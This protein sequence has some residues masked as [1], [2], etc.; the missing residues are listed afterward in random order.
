MQ[1]LIQWLQSRLTKN[2]MSTQGER[3]PKNSWLGWVRGLSMMFLLAG[4]VFSNANAQ[5]IVTQPMGGWRSTATGNDFSQKTNYPASSVNTEGI[6]PKAKIM[7]QIANFPKLSASQAK[8]SQLPAKLV[9]NGTDMPLKV[10]EGKFARP[11]AFGPGSNSVEVKYQ[12]NT[13]KVQFYE[14]KSDKGSAKLRVILSWDAD[15][16]DVDLH[17]V[18]PD[19]QHAWY[20]DQIVANGGGIDVDVTTGYGPEIY[21]NP[22]PLRGTYLIF[23]NY[24]GGYS[25]KTVVMATVTIITEE[26][27]GKEKREIFNVPL[28]K[29]GELQLVKSIQ[30]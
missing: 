28:R 29:P 10:N 5:V 3:I 7:G 30:Y 12:G 19:G 18:S 17:V 21:S 1:L 9:V 6:S 27:T 4:N 24:Y 26:G 11:W 20:G 14:A 2:L 16:T 25:Q 22:V 8:S 15:E 23:T 13:R